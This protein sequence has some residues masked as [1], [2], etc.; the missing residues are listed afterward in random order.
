MSLFGG[1][2]GGGAPLLWP[3]NGLKLFE[4]NESTSLLNVV[5]HGKSIGLK[6]R[7]LLVDE[8][9]IANMTVVPLP[10]LTPNEEDPEIPIV[11][12]KKRSVRRSLPTTAE[13][14]TTR[15]K[16]LENRK[17]RAVESSPDRKPSKRP[18]MSGDQNTRSN[19]IIFSQ[20]SATAVASAMNIPFPEDTSGGQEDP[21]STD[22]T[23][24]S[25]GVPDAMVAFLAQMKAD[26]VANTD[27]NTLLISKK[28]DD[29]QEKTDAAIKVINERLASLEKSR[30]SSESSDDEVFKTPGGK[31][32]PQGS[33]WEAMAVDKP[34]SRKR[35]S[36][37]K[38]APIPA[39]KTFVDVVN[40]QKKVKGIWTDFIPKEAGKRPEL[41]AP[42]EKKALTTALRSI[43]IKPVRVSLLTE[44]MEKDE[45]I[46]TNVLKFFETA[47]N[48]D[49]QM[50]AKFMER[51]VESIHRRS[52]PGSP[53]SMNHPVIITFK[54]RDAVFRINE[55]KPDL[56]S[57]R[58]SVQPCIPLYAASLGAWLRDRGYYFREFYRRQ[59]FMRVK[60]RTVMDVTSGRPIL[61]L[62][63]PNDR[64]EYAYEAD[65]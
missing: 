8:S 5:S 65:L 33:S 15:A 26:I 7:V 24:P 52:P 4:A 35:P 59:G 21:G 56:V 38:P 20:A 6:L 39:K 63:G 50:M 47:A 55:I 58:Y 61:I 9:A 18:T 2:W 49:K 16:R 57:P 34:E 45:D 43:E 12:T 19:Q 17:R 22:P 25:S 28:V 27:A 3:G 14:K 41:D 31:D 42:V 54:S 10:E 53:P 32:P 23:T 13:E 44:D 37:S 30:A 64:R 48:K 51:N 60:A 29:Y 62:K 40:T 1:G 11:E 36:T 46:K